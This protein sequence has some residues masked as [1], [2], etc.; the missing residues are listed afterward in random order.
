MGKKRD[1][2]NTQVR[3]GNRDRFIIPKGYGAISFYPILAEQ[4]VPRLEADPQSH[5]KNL[6]AEE[7]DLLISENR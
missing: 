5:I 3:A 6:N 4:G 2:E 1:P 7:I